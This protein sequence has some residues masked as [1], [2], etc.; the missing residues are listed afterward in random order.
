MKISRIILE[1]FKRFKSQEIDLR[2][3]LTGD[4]S[5]R[6]LILGDNGTGKTT[7]LQA[8]SLC[9]AMASKQIKDVSDFDWPG[10]VPARYEKW[11]LPVV[12]LDIHLSEEEIK[13]TI[14]I[15]KKWFELKKPSQK[16]MPG[17]NSKLT[18]RLKGQW[19]EAVGEDGK[20]SKNNLFQLKGRYYATQLIKTS[21]WT[22]DFFS[23]LPGFYWFDQFRNLSR[24]QFT[25]PLEHENE[26]GSGGRVS[27]N[28]GV[29]RYRRYLNSWKLK[30]FAGIGDGPDW[31]LELENSYK[32]IFPGRSFSGLEPMYKSGSPTPEEYF[33]V[34]SDGNR[35]YDIEEM[36]AGE[37]S[38]FP[39]LFEFVRLQIKNSIVLIDEIDLNLHPPLAQGLYNTLPNIGLGCQF[40]LTTHSESISSL[41]SAE[42]I[43]R[44]PGGKLCL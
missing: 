13:T 32:K 27:Y 30:Q 14:E 42:E 44:L 11:G 17:S 12:E 33:F 37:Q 1:N 18:L 29:S 35:T 40:L 25:L 21:P 36:S 16:I 6:F 7:V 24:P 19:I 8:V 9:F 34:F 43:F 38:V 26:N 15:W 41:S 4:I 5:N 2:N 22:R 31:L 23:I 39:M 10:W 3:K 20:A 28:I